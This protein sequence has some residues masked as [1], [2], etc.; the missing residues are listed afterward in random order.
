MANRPATVLA[1]LKRF[2]LSLPGTTPKSPWPGHD[3]VA[4][5]NKTFAYLSVE[6][7][8]LSMSVKLPVSGPQ[9]L[10]LPGA[11]PT[12]YGLGRCGW[13]SVAFAPDAAV[14]VDT[15]MH[16]M[17]ESYRAQASKRLLK[18]LETEQPWVKAGA[19]PDSPG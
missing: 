7:G 16:W 6:G 13:V 15:I 19:L 1:Q 18:T 17:M 14:P 2:G 11:R 10:L 3:D 4:V 9:V 8:Q 12:A 5:H